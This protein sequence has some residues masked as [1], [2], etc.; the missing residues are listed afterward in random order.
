MIS[1]LFYWGV[2]S[3][4]AQ[5]EGAADEDGRGPSI[6]DEFSKRR[7]KIAGNHTPAIS[8]SFYHRYQQDVHLLS[9]L[10][11]PNFRWSVSWSRIFPE[12]TG[13]VNQKGLDF[14]DRLIDEC[15]EKSIRPWITLYH[16]DLP[17][18]LEKRGGWT[19]RDTVYHF[20][21]Y[22]S[23][24]LKKYG[25][26]VQHWMA[27][28]E[29]LAFTGAGY[30]LGIHAPGKRGLQNF[31]PAAHHAALAQAMG[32]QIIREEGKTAGTTFSCSWITPFSESDRDV[33]AARRTDALMN[34][35]FLEPLLGEGYPLHDLPFLRR[36][37]KF[38]KAGDE[39]AMVAIP[40]FI[41][42]QNYTREVV[43][44]SWFTPY[45]QATLVGAPK[46]KVPHTLMKWEIFPEGIY[47]LLKKFSSY[48]AIKSIIVTE[49]G[50]AF[51]DQVI[52]GTV[53]DEQR[54]DYL[55]KYIAQVIRAK[56]EGVPVDGYFVW[57]LTDNFEWAEGYYP[58]FGLIHIDYTTQRRIIKSSALHYRQLIRSTKFGDINESRNEVSIKSD[59]DS[60]L[61]TEL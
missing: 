23:L 54:R 11:I 37:E 19:H 25:D 38:M 53:H 9:T 26:R 16:W 48:K 6:W 12:G 15:L 32:I 56:Q 40:D 21:D 61:P 8:S 31:L 46:R 57:S 5:T 18:A 3:A 58:R 13:H 43:K 39:K 45:M 7:G 35:F 20:C 4:A 1:S 34:R 47:L 22:A 59:S 14:Y 44:H 60:I 30:F 29:P 28:N 50:A 24:V 27:L 52:D 33:K 55:D 17:L 10:G 36:I 41:G 49:N 42:I 51:P 2:A